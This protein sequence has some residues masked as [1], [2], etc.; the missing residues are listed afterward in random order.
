MAD[1]STWR[2]SP[3]DEDRQKEE[4]GFSMVLNEENHHNP[5]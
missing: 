1:Q 5:I 2:W 4:Q 3:Q